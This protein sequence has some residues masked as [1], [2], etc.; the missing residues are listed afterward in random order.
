MVAGRCRSSLVA[1]DEGETDFGMFEGGRVDELRERE[2][3]GLL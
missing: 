3:D 1:A 2:E